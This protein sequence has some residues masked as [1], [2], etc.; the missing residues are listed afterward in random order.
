MFDIDLNIIK[1]SFF[2]DPTDTSSTSVQDFNDFE[3]NFSLY[4]NNDT[5]ISG[6]SDSLDPK[7]TAE[8]GYYIITE[9]S[10]PLSTA[11]GLSCESSARIDFIVN[12]LPSF[13]I[14]DEIIVCLNPLPDNPLEIGT[15]NWNGGNDPSIYNYSWSRA[16]LNG[17]DDIDYNENTET[18]KVDKGGVYTVIV[19]DPLTFCTRSKNITVTESEIAKITL[20]SYYY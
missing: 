13:D 6:P 3:F 10:N 14:D 19:E 8:N 17:V 16:D 4:D 11:L 7:I 15:S 12:P 5:L 9:I 2:I 18:I 20:G 1:N